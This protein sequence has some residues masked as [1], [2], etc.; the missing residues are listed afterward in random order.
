LADAANA[1]KR[2]IRH[3]KRKTWTLT[4]RECGV[5]DIRFSMPASR[6]GKCQIQATPES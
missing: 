5:S 6:I 4:K 3:I 1:H 2:G